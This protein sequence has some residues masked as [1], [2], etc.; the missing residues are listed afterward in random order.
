[1]DTDDLIGKLA[2]EGARKP[3]LHPVKQTFFWLTGAMLYLVMF[4]GVSGFRTDIVT[5]LE[6]PL[7]IAEL[8]LLFAMAVTA[9][10][11]AFYLSRPDNCQKSWIKYLPF[12]FTVLWAFV[13]FANGAGDVGFENLYHFVML[14]Q[15]DCPLHILLFSVPPGIAMFLLVRKGATIQ[16]CWAGSMAV[17]SVTSFGYLCMRLIESNDDPA[18]LIVWHALPML[19]MCMTGIL[20]GKAVLRWR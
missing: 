4:A 7:Y 5:K 15:F 11:A 18:H 17:W 3:L 2:E 20:I 13:A 6:Q 16:C 1:M 12:G 10:L 8:G 14:C 9:S 19:F